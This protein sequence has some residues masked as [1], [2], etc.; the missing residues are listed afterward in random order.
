MIERI[1][2]HHIEFYKRYIKDQ[3]DKSILND[4]L[5]RLLDIDHLVGTLEEQRRFLD[6]HAMVL[7]AVKDGDYEDIGEQPDVICDRCLSLHCRDSAVLRDRIGSWD[8]RFQAKQVII[9][10]IN[11]TQYDLTK[12]EDR[13]G[14][15]SYASKRAD[16][17]LRGS[18][19]S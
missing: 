18:V 19:Q 5:M 16:E 9:G 14:I 8:E 2:T 17:L 4:S 15:N 10:E 12:T 11:Q 1:R 13:A 6:A 3:D 7:R